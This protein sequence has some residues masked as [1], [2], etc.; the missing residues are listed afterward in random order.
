MGH[1]LHVKKRNSQE[2]V[3][4]YACCPGTEAETTRGFL[5]TLLFSSEVQSICMPSNSLNNIVCDSHLQETEGVCVGG[6][7]ETE[8]Q[9]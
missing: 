9:S 7:T 4:F 8:R 1:L 5:K 3:L 2:Q 6:E